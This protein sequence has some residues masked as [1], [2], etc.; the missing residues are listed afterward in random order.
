[1]FMPRQDHSLTA[2]R[3]GLAKQNQNGA[4]DNLASNGKYSITDLVDLDQLRRIFEKFAQAT[5]A[6]IGFLSFPDHELLITTNWRDVCSRFHRQ[7]PESANVCLESN[8]SMIAKLKTIGQISIEPC[9]HG[10]VDAGTPIIIRGEQ[11]ATLATGQ[12]FFHEPNMEWHKQHAQRFG[13]DVDEY[14]EAVRRVPVINEEQFKATIGFLGDLA[15]MIAELGYQNLEIRQQHA[16]LEKEI[17]ERKHAEE[18]RAKLELQIR[19]AQK[20]ESLGVLAGGIA[21]DFNNLLVGILGYADLAREEIPH[22][23]PVRGR[24]DGIVNAAK[25][26]ADLARQMLAYSGKG[27]FVVQPVNLNTVI[28]EMGRLIEVSISKR[29]VIKYDLANELPATCGD[30]SQ[31]GQVILNLITNAAEAIGDR[32]GVIGI[33]TGVTTCDQRYLKDTY[34]PETLPNGIYLYVEVADTGCG[35]DKETCD[36]VFDPFF[37]TKFTG[38][39]L[40]LAAVLGIVRGHKGTIKVYSEPG[41]GTTFKVLFPTTEEIAE[42]KSRDAIET[43]SLRGE[44]TVLV[45]DDEETV[46]TVAKDMLQK[47]GFEV[48]T[49]ADGVEAIEVFKQFEK[50]IVCVVLDLT[51]PRMN[52]EETFRI[53]KQINP[54]IPVILSSGYNEQEILTRFIGKGLAGF[55]QKPFRSA[56]VYAK[57]RES[58]HS[59]KVTQVR[60]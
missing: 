31:I 26:A 59:P 10:L 50:S 42:A 41:R 1:M 24:I 25:R 30:A 16:R 39:G 58:L 36:R 8:K 29:V 12:V 43:A 37:S 44:G 18:D 35:M 32:S 9:A 38:R 20:L 47:A 33:S 56:D 27:R 2:H 34:V 6:T 52:G 49:A 11:L 13:Y 22:T 19:H 57:L 7:N 51:M 4:N 21:H 45:V 15:L 54:Q 55:L 23:S 5:G 46:R 28:E 40:G 60:D 14:L 3:E 17:A 48:L 53:L